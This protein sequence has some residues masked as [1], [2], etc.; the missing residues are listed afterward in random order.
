MH[1]TGYVIKFNYFLYNENEL[2][3]TGCRPRKG[4]PDSGILEIFAC[5]IRNPGFW[6]PKYG[7]SFNLIRKTP[8]PQRYLVTNE[9]TETAEEKLRVS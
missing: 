5:G 8:K 2:S 3:H 9:F 1:C 4:N 6:N 7:S